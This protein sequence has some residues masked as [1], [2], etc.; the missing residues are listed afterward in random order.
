M[1]FPENRTVRR[2]IFARRS[3]KIDCFIGN[4]PLFAE[5]YR[6]PF[7]RISLIEKNDSRLDS[8]AANKRKNIAGPLTLLYR[9]EIESLVNCP[10]KEEEK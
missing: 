6:A 10:N 3:R 5:R 1:D 7:L 8:H 9:K 4:G 2:A